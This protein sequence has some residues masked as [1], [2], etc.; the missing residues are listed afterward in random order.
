MEIADGGWNNF[1]EALDAV[2]GA[3]AFDAFASTGY[4]SPPSKTAIYFPLFRPNWPDG[5]DGYLGKRRH[6]PT[7]RGVPKNLVTYPADG[8]IV[9]GIHYS[10]RSS[11]PIDLIRPKVLP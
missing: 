1:T 8:S 11:T 10:G 2:P 4:S 7:W 3:V 9:P 5:W 6:D